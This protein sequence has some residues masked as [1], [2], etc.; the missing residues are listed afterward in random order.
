M[1]ESQRDQI[2]NQSFQLSNTQLTTS[3]LAA[4]LSTVTALETATKTLRKQTKNLDVS[5]IERLQD[6]LEDFQRL[7]EE[8]NETVGRNYSVPD[9]DED[10]LDAELEALGEDL[11][12]P[13]EEDHISSA[14]KGSNLNTPNLSS[15]LGGGAIPDFIDENDGKT[16]ERP[17]EDRIKA[18]V[19]WP[20]NINPKVCNLENYIDSNVVKEITCMQLSNDERKKKKLFNV[21]VAAAAVVVERLVEQLVYFEM[22]L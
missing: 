21:A 13:S 2:T 19:V 17:M 22:T 6:E 16:S 14:L 5:K 11:W 3:S 15:S 9:V 10:E 20:E 1:Y 4:T 12:S 8:V 18:G 7:T